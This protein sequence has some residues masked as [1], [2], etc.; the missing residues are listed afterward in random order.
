MN[1]Y[2]LSDYESQEIDKSIKFLKLLHDTPRKN[3]NIKT[4]P[5]NDVEPFWNVNQNIPNINI[6]KEKGLVCVGLINLVRRFMKLEIPG[7]ITGKEKLYWPGGT[8]AWFNYLKNENRLEEINIKTIYPKGT[9]LLQN[10]NNI[11][12]GHV[13]VTINSNKN[14]LLNSEIIHNSSEK[15]INGT[16]IHLLKDY[17]NFKRFTHICLPQNWIL[18][19]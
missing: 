9:L 16:K 7:N 12:Q 6:I 4:P 13:A 14:G 1:K 5:Q 17:I 8:D 10:Y 2:Y 3:Y 15:Y 18:K 19:N 11:D